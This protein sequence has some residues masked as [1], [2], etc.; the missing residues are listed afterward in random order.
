MIVHTFQLFD[1]SIFGIGSDDYPDDPEEAKEL[2]LVV[3]E[4]PLYD[5]E[6]DDQ[7]DKWI[8]KRFSMNYYVVFE[9]YVNRDIVQNVAID[10]D[11]KY[12]RATR[13]PF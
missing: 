11:Q 8:T 12:R 1:Y 13:T 2:G 6:Q 5:A 9:L 7:N 4:D 10:F 3:S